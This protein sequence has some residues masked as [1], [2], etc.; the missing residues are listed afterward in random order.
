MSLNKS[1]LQFQTC[2]KQFQNCV[3]I[4]QTSFID[5]R[6]FGCLF[7]PILRR[8]VNRRSKFVLCHSYSN[9]FHQYSSGVNEIGGGFY[10]LK[11]NATIKTFKRMVLKITFLPL[12]PPNDLWILWLLWHDS[13]K[14]GQ[15]TTEL[16]YGIKIL[17]NTTTRCSV[18]FSVIDNMLILAI[19][20][21]LSI[22]I[23]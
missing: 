2:F 13:V 12:W 21:C 8:V 4:F 14:F 15:S 6:R 9:F 17:I 3:T 11:G 23:C 10:T 1:R 5:F 16:Q 19:L 22:T 20:T 18:I 7:R